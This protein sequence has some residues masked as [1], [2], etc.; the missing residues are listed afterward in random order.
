[1]DIFL[2]QSLPPKTLC[3]HHV[4]GR[5]GHGSPVKIVED[6]QSFE[7]KYDTLTLT[8]KICVLQENGFKEIILVL[9]E[10]LVPGHTFCCTTF[11]VRSSTGAQQSHE[12]APK[13]FK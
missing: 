8:L 6:F 3:E 1:V 12:R 10:S 11:L 7:K 9:F 4:H 13:T 2:N 5:H